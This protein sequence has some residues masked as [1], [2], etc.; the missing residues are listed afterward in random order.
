MWMPSDWGDG[1]GTKDDGDGT[2]RA[3]LGEPCGSMV[4]GDGVPM[5]AAD[6]DGATLL[7][8]WESRTTGSNNISCCAANHLNNSASF[9]S[10][11]K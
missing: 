4:L 7:C 6:G 2:C 10:M 5:S 3:G 8:C 11:P 1:A 9:G